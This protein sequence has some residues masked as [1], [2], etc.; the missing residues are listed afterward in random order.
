M[1]SKVREKDSK[2]KNEVKAH[3]PGI[4][5]HSV[6]HV[7]WKRSV[8]GMTSCNMSYQI[9]PGLAKVQHQ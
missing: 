8:W 7:R 6:R 9:C 3:S 5:R 2:P 4:G 1:V